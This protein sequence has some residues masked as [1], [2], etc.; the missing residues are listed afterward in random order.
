M[1]LIIRQEKQGRKIEI[2]E[3]GT[4][5]RIGRNAFALQPALSFLVESRGIDIGRE[6][7]KKSRGSGCYT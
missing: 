6:I 1:M 5:A 2:Y 7:C 4:E 3:G